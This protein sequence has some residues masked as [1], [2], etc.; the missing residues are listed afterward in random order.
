[1]TG[2]YITFRFLIMSSCQ[3][4]NYRYELRKKLMEVRKKKIEIRKKKIE[5]RKK[6]IEVRKKKEKMKEAKNILKNKESMERLSKEG[7]KKRKCKKQ[8]R[9]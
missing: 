9:K 4:K 2:I 8:F 6:K 7:R 3:N 5:V 1:M